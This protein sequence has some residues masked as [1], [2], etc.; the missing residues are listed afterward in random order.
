[1]FEKASSVHD[2]KGELK[3]RVVDLYTSRM[4]NESSDFQTKFPSPSEGSLRIL[5]C[6]EKPSFTVDSL[7]QKY[8]LTYTEPGKDMSTA[9]VTMEGTHSIPLRLQHFLKATTNQA[10]T[11]EVVSSHESL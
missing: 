3:K 10:S 6:N 9:S 11:R 8:K 7:W 5:R 2:A 4:F 1:M